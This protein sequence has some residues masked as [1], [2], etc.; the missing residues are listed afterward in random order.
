MAEEKPKQNLSEIARKKRYL[1]LIE[2]IHSG[3]PLSNREI[4]ELEEFEKEPQ[5]D[6]IVK[7]AE[8]VAEVM[9]VSERT[10]YRWRNEG[11]PVTK[12]GYYDLEKIRIW[13]EEKEKASNESGKIFW[14]AKIRKYKATLL[15]IDLKKAQNELVLREEVEKA[16]VARIIAV[17]RSFLALPTR[18]API[19]AM[20]EPREIETL[21]YEEIGEIIDEFAGVK[22]EDI[23]TRQNDME[24]SS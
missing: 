22:N 2:K 19:L 5:S 21:L 14:E 7:S 16:E 6:T 8:E 24:K 11:M 15:E 17:K 20:K 3:K 12:D 23:D 13:V 4:R 1:H 10:I 9:D 18:M